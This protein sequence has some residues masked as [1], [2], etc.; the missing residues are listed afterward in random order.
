MSRTKLSVPAVLA[1]LVVCTVPAPT[2]GAEFGVLPACSHWAPYFCTDAGYFLEGN[3]YVLRVS[4]RVCNEGLQFVR[5]DEGYTASADVAIVVEDDKNR[6]VT[7]DTYRIRLKAE[8]YHE[9]TSVDSCETRS[10]SFRARPGEL[11]MVVTVRDGDSG[12]KSKVAAAI[13][14]PSLDRRPTLSDVCLLYRDDANTDGKWEGF[15][16]NVVRIYPSGSL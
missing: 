12:R 9:T 1:L 5:E 7:G 3:T 13:K 2:P 11:G 6:Q 8:K 10:V 4:F 15:S 16:P 14:I